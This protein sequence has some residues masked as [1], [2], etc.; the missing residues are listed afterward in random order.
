MRFELASLRF[1]T[2][3]DEHRFDLRRQ[4]IE[5][6]V[7]RHPGPERADAPAVP[8]VTDALEHDVEALGAHGAERQPHVLEG[9]AIDFADETQGQVY[10]F[11]IHPAGARDAGAQAAQARPHLRW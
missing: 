9:T 10:L 11:R 2:C 7:G 1:E 5:R 4:T 3:A 8:E 6:R